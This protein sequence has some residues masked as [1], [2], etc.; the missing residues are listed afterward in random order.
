M[1]EWL[2]D[3][4]QRHWRAFIENAIRLIELLDQELREGHGLTLAEYEILV[5]L[6]E[7]PARCMRMAEL[8][9]VSYYSRSRLSHSVSRLESRGVVGRD[10]TPGDK[11][12]VVA[13]LTDQG[14][15]VLRRAAPDN[16]RIVRSYFV[17]VVTP[18]DLTAVGRAFRAVAA[19]LDQPGR[20]P[21]DAAV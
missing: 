8:A 12:G 20:S 15:D 11:R 5:R 10:R 6:S 9:D 1:P 3:D 13:R 18:A 17:D 14:M 21:D 7:A 19:Q 4:Q 16:L 2:D